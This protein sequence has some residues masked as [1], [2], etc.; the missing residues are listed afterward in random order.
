MAVRTVAIALTLL[1]ASAGVA[2]AQAAVCQASASGPDWKAQLTVGYDAA[3]AE[4]MTGLRIEARATAEDLPDG[5]ALTWNV[6]S[7][8]LDTPTGWVRV[9]RQSAAGQP[10]R[11]QI[12]VAAPQ[13]FDFN[14]VMMGKGDGTVPLSLR[15]FA[16]AAAAITRPAPLARSDGPWPTSTAGLQRFKVGE[17][18]AAAPDNAEAVALAA[19]LAKARKVRIEI[20]DGRGA[21]AGAVVFRDGALAEALAAETGLKARVA[22]DLAAGRCRKA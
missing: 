6:V 14:A 19:R 11:A 4:R 7:G 16:D 2:Q 1:A 18:R 21:R 10:P 12:D 17:A 8:N 15:L 20:L 22:A 13:M 9:I 5:A 3:G